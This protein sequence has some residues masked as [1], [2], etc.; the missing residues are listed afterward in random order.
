L[1]C[2][3]AIVGGFVFLVR[4]NRIADEDFRTCSGASRAYECEA[5]QRPITLSSYSPGYDGSS[6][7]WEVDVQLSEHS[8]YFITGLS[9]SDVAQLGDA[10]TMP[11]LYRHDRPVAIIAPDG[12]AA[13]APFNVFKSFLW[14]VLLGGG[15]VLLAFVWMIA[16]FV[17]GGRVAPAY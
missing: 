14:V 7:E 13:P 4:A 3:L 1:V 6:R 10:T 16:G 11:V 15:A 9:D 12:S 17:R 2:V 5:Q 8:F